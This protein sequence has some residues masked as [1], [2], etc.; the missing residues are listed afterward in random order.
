MMSLFTTPKPRDIKSTHGVS[1]G[2]LFFDLAFVAAAVQ[3]GNFLS[4]E[5][6]VLNFL[7]FV[8]LTFPI[9]I[10]WFQ[11]ALFHN[12]YQGDNIYIRFFIFIQIFLLALLSITIDGATTGKIVTFV[13]TIMMLRLTSG[14]FF[15]LQYRNQKNVLFKWIFIGDSISLLLWLPSFFLR[16]SWLIPLWLSSSFIKLVLIQLGLIKKENYKRI[17][18]LFPYLQERFALLTIIL[19]GETLLKM[20]SISQDSKQTL[21]FLL[22]GFLAILNLSFAWWIYFHKLAHSNF[23]QS[24]ISLSVWIYSHIFISLG[25]I[26][27]AVGTKKLL[28][29]IGK[30]EFPLKYELLIVASSI[31]YLFSIFILEVFSS[32]TSKK[33]HKQVR[34]LYHVFAMTTLFIILAFISYVDLWTFVFLTFI[35]FSIV[36]IGDI[37]LDYLDYKEK[38]NK[39]LE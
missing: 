19:L 23:S 27:S 12:L 37:V 22:T 29:S 25:L 14:V 18:E 1:W 39:N 7:A 3:L 20:V 30:N 26:G 35:A 32:I 15:Y 28:L 4:L 5:I 2:E 11:M 8:A 9:W 13:S 38:K 17:K 33:E 34:L 6:S 16:E 36:P 24:I 31:I 10:T 21:P